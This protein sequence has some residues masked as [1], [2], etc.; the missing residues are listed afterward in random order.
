MLLK[1]NFKVEF[2]GME[3]KFILIAFCESM[4]SSNGKKD[5]VSYTWQTF[6]FLQETVFECPSCLHNFMSGPILFILC[7]LLKY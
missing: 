3:E 6:F 7:N 1:L 2:T 5:K 4:H